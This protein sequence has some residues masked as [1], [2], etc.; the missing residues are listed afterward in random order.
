MGTDKIKSL[1]GGPALPGWS[2]AFDLVRSHKW[3]HLLVMPTITGL[4]I[5]EHGNDCE[6]VLSLRKMLQILTIDFL[7]IRLNV[8]HYALIPGEISQ[9][10]SAFLKLF[11]V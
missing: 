5:S 11:L 2:Q 1:R 4:G 3:Q 6:Y 8:V 7:L 10:R 9:C